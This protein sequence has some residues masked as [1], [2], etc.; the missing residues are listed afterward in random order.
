M[1]AVLTFNGGNFAWMKILTEFNK[2]YMINSYVGL[3]S[4]ETRYVKEACYN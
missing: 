3:R 2:K 1:V 4:L